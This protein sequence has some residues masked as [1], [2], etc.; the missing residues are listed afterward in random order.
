M[1]LEKYKK[2]HAL[3]ELYNQY[4]NRWDKDY[5]FG[6]ATY[7]QDISEDE[8]KAGWD[9]FNLI[10]NRDRAELESKRVENSWDLVPNQRGLE[11]LFQELNG[12]NC[13]NEYEEEQVNNKFFIRGR[14]GKYVNWSKL[15]DWKS[16]RGDLVFEKYT[17]EWK[18]DFGGEG[19]GDAYWLVFAVVDNKMGEE[20]SYWKWDGW[21]ASHDGGYL[22]TLF[23]VE[24]KEE[25]RIVWNTKK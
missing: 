2:L 12:Y 16:E 9:E 13:E 7:Q 20:I 14:D 5:D 21:Y 10:P 18:E 6:R 25:T 11:T 23:E 22:E 17:L 4:V 19:D 15:D 1:E 3:A 24:P 8:A